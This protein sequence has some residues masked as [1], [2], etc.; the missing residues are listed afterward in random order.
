[1]GSEELTRRGFVKGT[2]ATG[3]AAATH[4][5]R[6]ERKPKHRHRH[7]NAHTRH[8]DVAVVGAGLAGLTAA[9]N[10]VAAGHSVIVLEARDRVGGRIWNHDLGGG[11]ISER[12]ATFVG[13]TQ[14]HIAGARVSARHRHVPDL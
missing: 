11:H 3:A 12:G 5:H 9:R 14:D 6:R 1:M 4:K 10:I 7:T 2:V 13:P 8:A